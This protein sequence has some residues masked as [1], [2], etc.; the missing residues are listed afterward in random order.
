MRLFPV[1][2]NGMH[3]DK[4]SSKCLS[5]V[6]WFLFIYQLRI[7]N[8][9]FNILDPVQ[10]HPKSN[11]NTFIMA[12]L[13]DPRTFRLLSNNSQPRKTR[14]NTHHNWPCKSGAHIPPCPRSLRRHLPLW[15]NLGATRL[16]AQILPTILGSRFRIRSR[17]SDKR[18]DIWSR[19]RCVQRDG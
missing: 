13:V 7:Q 6:F 14:N 12:E 2:E 11:S 3:D 15:H 8:S 4:D 16:G 1:L 9:E 17:S 5:Y 19:R 10:Y 18:R